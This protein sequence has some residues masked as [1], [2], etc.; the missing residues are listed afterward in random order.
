[1]YITKQRATTMDHSVEKFEKRNNTEQETPKSD[2]MVKKLPKDDTCSKYETKIHQVLTT[3]RE[4]NM[5]IQNDRCGRD[6][7]GRLSDTAHT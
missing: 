1:M 6:P 2:T 3:S 7:V 4:R 5:T